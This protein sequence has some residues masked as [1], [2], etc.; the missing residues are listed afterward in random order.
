[1]TAYLEYMWFTDM[2]LYS[3]IP[4]QETWICIV[5]IIITIVMVLTGLK[6]YFRKDLNA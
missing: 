2:D 4:M 3:V 5:W 1:M 6:I